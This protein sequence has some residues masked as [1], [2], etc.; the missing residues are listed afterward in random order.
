MIFYRFS[1]AGALLLFIILSFNPVGMARQAGGTESAREAVVRFFNL[2]KAGQYAELYDYLPNDMQQRMTRE[3]LDRSLSR[4]Q[5]FL[6]I[7][8]IVVGRTRR[9]EQT[10]VVETTIFGR[11]K[12]PLTIEGAPVS[13]GRVIAQQIV[14]KEGGRWKIVTADNR[15]RDLYLKEHPELKNKIPLTEPQLSIKQN[16]KWTPLS[17][18]LS[19]MRR[20]RPPGS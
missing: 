11:L 20:N 18:V 12:R 5:S 1:S 4:V 13:E 6:L 7:D 16:G 8:R 17:T 9:I 3:E 15:T 19:K 10:A 2:L 14:A